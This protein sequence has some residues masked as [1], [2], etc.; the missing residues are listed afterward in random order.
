MD[1]SVT[2]NGK[3]AGVHCKVDK[4]AVPQ[5]RFMHFQLLKN[6]SGAIQYVFFT[7]IFNE[8]ANLSRR[9]LLSKSNGVGN[10][11]T[12][13]F[14][15]EFFRSSHWKVAAESRNRQS[16]CLLLLPATY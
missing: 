14:S 6:K 13:F 2:E 9:L 15:K 3:L 7:F 4:Y 5:C 10:G 11:L 8:Q 16:N 12:L 1:S